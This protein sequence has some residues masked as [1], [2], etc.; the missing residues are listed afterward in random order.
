MIRQTEPR[1]ECFGPRQNPRIILPMTQTMPSLPN[2]NPPP[3]KA[4]SASVREHFSA[5]VDDYDT[6]A[7][8]VVMRN[9]EI[10]QEIVDATRQHSGD[11]GRCLDIGCGTGHGMELML[12][13]YPNAEVVGIDFSSRMLENAEQRLHQFGHRVKL[14]EGDAK[15]LP[16]LSGLAGSFDC[17]VSALTIHNL[18]SSQK[19]TVFRHV[20]RVLR[21]EG[22]FVNADF[23]AFADDELS[24]QTSRVYRRFVRSNLSDKKLAIWESHIQ[25]DQPETLAAQQQMLRDSG[26]C[27]LE[28]RWLFVNEA[29]Y[30]AKRLTA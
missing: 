9:D 20:A 28:L 22:V 1:L 7:D 25:K 29:V 19:A 21:P 18:D 23:V 27:G 11:V 14:I 26:F 4:A 10:H 8:A 6:V 12:L 24:D 17:V 3:V 2:Q 5:W 30:V 16:S 15:D 13:E